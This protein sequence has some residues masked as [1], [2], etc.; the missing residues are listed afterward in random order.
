VNKRAVL[1]GRVVEKRERSS[2]RVEVASTVAQKRSGSDGGIFV[3]S[4][5]KQRSSSECSIEAVSGV[6]LQR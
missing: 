5:G 2:G 4:V 1:F 3:G 6:A